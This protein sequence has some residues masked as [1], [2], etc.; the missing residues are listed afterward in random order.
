MTNEGPILKAQMQIEEFLPF[1]IHYIYVGL[2]SALGTK[3][4]ISV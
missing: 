4:T 1:P 2:E 3:V